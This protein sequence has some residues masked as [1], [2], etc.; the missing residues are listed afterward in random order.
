MNDQPTVSK[1]GASGNQTT[2]TLY[3]S[4]GPDGKVSSYPSTSDEIFGRG[5]TLCDPITQI[6]KRI[7]AFFRNDPDVIVS[8]T[9]NNSVPLEEGQDQHAELRLYLTDE[10][11]AGCL[12]NIVRHQHVYEELKGMDGSHLRNH[13]LDVKVFLATSIDPMDPAQE[14][15]IPVSQLPTPDEATQASYDGGDMKERKCEW[16]RTAFKRNRNVVNLKT[17]LDPLTGTRWDFIECSRDPVTFMEDN[18]LSFKG[19]TSVLPADL[20]PLVFVFAG[21]F[22]ISTYAKDVNVL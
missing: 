2:K 22:Q 10:V 12:D 3:T 7:E 8:Y 17:Y 6:A 15:E 1:L 14:G 13:Y 16:L 9:I 19:Y 18:L 21:G 4:V 20:M 11:K 5:L